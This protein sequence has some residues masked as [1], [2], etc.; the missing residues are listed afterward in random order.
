MLIA[1]AVE[2]STMVFGDGTIKV[3]VNAN[4]EDEYLSDALLFYKA[5]SE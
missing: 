3:I 5:S 2:R 4:I 1:S